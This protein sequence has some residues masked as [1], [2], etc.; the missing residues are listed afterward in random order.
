MH[1]SA[2]SANCRMVRAGDWRH[3]GFAPRHVSRHAL[4]E[5]RL[6][7]FREG[8]RNDEK[9]IGGRY[10]G[11]SR[12]KRTFASTGTARRRGFPGRRRGD[13]GSACVRRRRTLGGTVDD[14]A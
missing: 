11:I 5:K 1:L 4:A 6:G 12:G 10:A 8:E 3:L 9:T 7:I 14:G 2:A 13:R